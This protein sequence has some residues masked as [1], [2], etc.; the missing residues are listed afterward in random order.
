MAQRNKKEKL[1]LMHFPHQIISSFSP[2]FR[3]KE[4]FSLLPRQKNDMQFSAQSNS[5]K[6]S[7]IF[8]F[9]CQKPEKMQFHFEITL[10]CCLKSCTISSPR[11][12]Y[13]LTKTHNLHLLHYCSE[14][15]N[16]MCIL[17]LSVEASKRWNWNVTKVGWKQ[18]WII[19][20]RKRRKSA[21]VLR[22]KLTFK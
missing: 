20:E 7:S 9:L 13:F 19:K 5:N 16:M 4:K 8:P 15:S 12:Q 3:C 22:C 2:F 21:I 17:N 6:L 14:K 11:Q 1:I 10:L 18:I